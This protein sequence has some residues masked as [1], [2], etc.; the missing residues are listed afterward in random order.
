M[1][2]PRWINKQA[3][4]LLHPASLAAFG[5]SAGIRDDALLDSALARARNRF[6]Y[7]PTADIAEL[8]ACYGFGL[9]K[10]HPFV[11]GNKRA[12]LHAIGVFLLINNYQLT[13][14]QPEAVQVI[15]GLAAGE[16]TE[17][18]LATWIRLN[19]QRRS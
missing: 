4:L 2:E 12:A 8:A 1:T 3:L 18:Q 10:N 9:A 19:S 15:L 17:A 13:A 7:E 16:I 11:D 5:G 6:L 14:S